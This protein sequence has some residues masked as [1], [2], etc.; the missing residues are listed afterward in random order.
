VNLNL[1]EFRLSILNTGDM[2][3]FR[4]PASKK[5]DEYIGLIIN[6]DKTCSDGEVTYHGARNY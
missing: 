1:N 3:C 2:G 6:V 5:E 4:R